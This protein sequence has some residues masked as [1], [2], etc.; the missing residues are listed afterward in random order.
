MLSSSGKPAPPSPPA[1]GNVATGI[2]PTGNSART[3]ISA[4]QVPASGGA[5]RGIELVDPDEANPFRK[6]A[7]WFALAT[8][9]VRFAVLPELLFYITGSNTYVLYLVAPVAAIGCLL[10][11][12]LRRTFRS[13]ASYLFLAFYVWMI[14]DTPFS[15]WRGDSTRLVIGFGRT[16]L[17]LLFLC[18]G[19]AVNWKEVRA[20]ITT[21]A[22]AGVVTLFVAG[23]LSKSEN[24]RI[25]LDLNFDGII[26]NANDLA[27]HLMLVLPFVFFLA[28][29]PGRFIVVRVALLAGIVFGVLIILK[30]GSRGA[31]VGLIF[32]GLF[33]LL[34]ASGTQR[35]GFILAIPLIAAI[36]VPVLPQTTRSRLMMLFVEDTRAE[37]EN[38]AGE[39]S[40]TRAYL[41]K[42]SLLYTWE[43]PVF[44][45]GPGQFENFEGSSSRAQGEHGS[46]HAT[47]C[48]YTQI[49]S[50]C[51]IPALIF[52]V[53]ALLVAGH[54]LNKTY[55]QAVL[56]RHKEIANASFCI[57]L[58]LIGYLTVAVFLAMAYRFT[59]PALVGLAISF[60]FAA[61]KELSKGTGLA[62][63]RIA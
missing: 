45:V 18:A 34:R 47:H 12:G 35:L 33:C 11:G 57:L 58:A 6:L 16:D 15:S 24:G 9:F 21:I 32:I 17:I 20:V 40:A 4:R 53:G 26:S 3:N 43:H 14:V 62:G 56:Q 38:E 7:F 49:S 10:T 44:G 50:E 30:T 27:A 60:Y 42:K 41:F 55:K 25:A 48:T 37:G 36:L 51:G 39:S 23:V 29:K 52:F 19:L 61:K 46:W 28:M 1:G 8:I 31:L 54:L 2:N 59:F 5:L 13:P 63:L 22:L